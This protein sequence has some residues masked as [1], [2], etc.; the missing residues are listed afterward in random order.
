MRIA[1]APRWLGVLITSVLLVGVVALV[2]WLT[3][4]DFA[5]LRPLSA[6]VP[7]ATAG[8]VAAPVLSGLLGIGVGLL[9]AR[10]SRWITQ[11]ALV[12]TGGIACVLWMVLVSA[13]WFA[14]QG[15]LLGLPDS[16][17]SGRAVVS[18][19]S[20]LLLPATAV[21]FGAAA[22]IAARVQAATRIVA[23]E[24]HVQTALS[25]GQR[26]V[27]LVIRR[28]VQRTLPTILAVL[29][30]ELLVLYAGSLTVQ[31]LLTTPALATVLPP[32]LPAESL[33]FVLGVALLGI[34]GLISA[35]LV[36]ATTVSAPA[37]PLQPT[38]RPSTWPPEW[39]AVPAADGHVRARSGGRTLPST[40]FRSSDLLD[41][42]DLRLHRGAGPEDGS[43]PAGVNLTVDWGQALAVVGGPDDGAALLC[44]AIA[45]LLPP[46]ATISSG[47]ILFDGTE[48]IGLPERQFRGLRGGRI[49][50]LAASGTHRLDPGVRIGRHLVGVAA[51]RP[52]GSRSRAGRD[53]LDLLTGVGVDDAAAVFA[54]YPHQ[55]SPAT[56]QRVLLAGALALQPQLLIADNPTGF[57]AT[58]DETA[59]LDVLHTLQQEQGFTLI[60]A[61]ARLANVARCDRVAV[62]NGGRI[63]EH[64][65]VDDVLTDPRDPHTR[66]LLFGRSDPAQASPQPE[67]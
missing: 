62:M 6:L 27:P 3:G 4:P 25:Q 26:T 54:A 2:A 31:A 59:F 46:P 5:L 65:S 63:V 41:I 56:V 10:Q 22:V 42:R 44:Q 34:V 38:V 23:G 57:L 50:F 11:R 20:T 24:G 7:L 64:A 37:S 19:L 9:A 55:L 53:A 8:T 67:R 28:V 29:I 52:G 13:F 32:L 61:S 17:T 39:A 30:V 1:T 12:L 58:R 18:T 36:R 60:V 35:A 16:S 21:V 14:V 40:D 51:R 15:E 43:R 33:P 48:L 47:S 49:G 45:G 66:H